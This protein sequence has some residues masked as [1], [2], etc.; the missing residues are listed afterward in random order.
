MLTIKYRLI[1]I[2]DQESI[3]ENRLFDTI[4][5]EIDQSKSIND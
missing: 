5:I 1:G 4:T 3:T 2:L